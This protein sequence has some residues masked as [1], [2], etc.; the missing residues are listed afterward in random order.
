MERPGEISWREF[1]PEEYYKPTPEEEAESSWRLAKAG[2]V[3][4]LTIDESPV[5]GIS[6]S[7]FAC[8]KYPKSLA[9]KRL[10]I[11]RPWRFV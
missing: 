11:I 9:E 10:P 7:F 6:S 3:T 8:E 5:T 1:S 2:N 4:S